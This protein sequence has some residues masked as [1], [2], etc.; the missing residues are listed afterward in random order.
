[1]LSRWRDG[2]KAECGLGRKEDLIN[3]QFSIV[4]QG[5]CDTATIALVE[6]AFLSDDN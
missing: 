4:I 3:V 2:I 6:S 1:M 5:N